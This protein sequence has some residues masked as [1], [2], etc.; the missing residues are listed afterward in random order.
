MPYGGVRQSYMGIMEKN[1]K[2]TN[3]SNLKEHIE[4][5]IRA[6]FGRLNEVYEHQEGSAVN[7]SLK[8]KNTRLIFPKYGQHRNNE[9]RVS[10]QELR[11]AFVETFNKYCDSNHLNLFYSVETPTN[12]K[13]VF[14][15]KEK[16]IAVNPGD[17]G[18][19]SAAFDLVIHDSSLKRV[20]LIEFKALNSS[21]FEHQKDYAK[22]SNY[23]EGG[24]DVLRY[25]IEL[26]KNSDNGTYES[27]R[28]KI[29][30][31][32]NSD[33]VSFF[34]YDLNKKREITEDIQKCDNL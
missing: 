30:K 25:F 18:G 10:E 6:T 2:V 19:V 29:N 15:D 22:L 24:E 3:V 31:C 32:E 4:K 5:I 27:I 23:D 21:E 13:Y 16:P 1:K 34:C 12:A 11:F 9:T 33:K 14:K 28:G 17:T 8:K 26:V 20:A 7:A